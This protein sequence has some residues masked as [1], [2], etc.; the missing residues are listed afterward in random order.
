MQERP[1][2]DIEKLAML[3]RIQ[4]T[5]E[6]KAAFSGQ[7]SDILGFFQKLQEVDVEGIR[8]M[9]HPFEAEPFLR[10]DVPAQPWEPQR[11][12]ANAPAARDNQVIVPKVVEDA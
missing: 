12:L 4:L 11:S 7:L 6:E 3:S 1:E 8:P 9:A 5:D 10:E 2:V